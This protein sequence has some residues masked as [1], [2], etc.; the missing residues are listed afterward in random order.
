MDSP[1]RLHWLDPRNPQQ[2]FPPVHLAMR[3]PNGLLAIGGDLTSARLLRAYSQGIFP[4]YNPDEPIL[5]WCPNPRAV[6]TPDS[7]HISRS[8]A[9]AI[10]RADYAV[11]LDQAFGDVLEACAGVRSRSRGT[12]LGEE[13][14]RAYRQLHAEGHAHSLE[15]WRDRQLIGGLY[16]IALGRV[17]FGESMFSHADN[18]S[19]IALHWLA[20]QLKQWQFEMIDCQV[21][22]AHLMSLGAQELPRDTFLRKLSSAV[23][24][25]HAPGIW[26][27]EIDVPNSSVHLGF[28]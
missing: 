26:Q 19:K 17:F 23:R 14:K 1:V 10:R 18:A 24:I 27:F 12:W 3:D 15:L 25:D 13:M 7:L 9:K 6:L 11:T 4:W 5:W 21:S 22:S 2:P 16:G 28:S 8:T 20:R